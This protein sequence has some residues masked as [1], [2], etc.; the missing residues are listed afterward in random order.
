M[1]YK[2]INDLSSVHSISTY[3]SK[4]KSF[5]QNF[6]NIKLL[7]CVADVAYSLVSFFLKAIFT[8][9]LLLTMSSFMLCNCLSFWLCGADCNFLF[10]FI[11]HHWCFV[12]AEIMV[13]HSNTSPAKAG[14]IF[15]RR[16]RPHLC[17]DPWN[18][19]HNTLRLTRKRK[20][21]A[22]YEPRQAGQSLCNGPTLLHTKSLKPNLILQLLIRIY[23]WKSKY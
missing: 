16:A 11:K 23:G 14:C 10:P 21:K 4:S 6:K 7:L 9:K 13:K 15:W 18:G 20:R 17:T 5:T 22:Q 2:F 19:P 1:M 3:P 8:S 12:I